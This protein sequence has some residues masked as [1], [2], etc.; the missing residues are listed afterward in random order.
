[1]LQRLPLS[2]DSTKPSFRGPLRIL[3]QSGPLNGSWYNVCKLENYER[4]LAPFAVH[5]SALKRFDASRTTVDQLLARGL[6]GD[7]GI[8]SAITHHRPPAEAG[9]EVEF[10]VTFEGVSL[11]VYTPGSSLTRVTVF[12]EYVRDNKLDP[13]RFQLN[14]DWTARAARSGGRR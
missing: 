5:V 6:N 9:G 13:A 7:F 11:P 3:G 10:L 12:T 8:V 4:R 14:N 2:L 1:V